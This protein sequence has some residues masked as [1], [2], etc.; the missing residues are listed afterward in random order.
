[1]VSSDI[2]EASFEK[3][4]TSKSRGISI[5]QFESALNNIGI[6]LTSREIQTIFTDVNRNL[7]SDD[8]ARI[9]L[10]EILLSFKRKG[11]TGKS[12]RKSGG[13]GDHSDVLI[14]DSV[15]EDLSQST[16]AF[17]KV[18]K[19]SL[20]LTF[21]VSTTRN[22][23]SS[24]MKKPQYL[25][26]LEK[27]GCQLEETHLNL[28]YEIFDITLE[29]V[30]S[31]EN[32]LL[33]VY[34]ISSSTMDMSLEPAVILSQICHKR[35]IGSKDFI[36]N[37]L[38]YE[39]S[40][41]GYV[42]APSFESV[43][44]KL[45]GTRPGVTTSQL[46]D[47]LR[48]FDPDEDN[49]IDIGLLLSFLNTITSPQRV[50]E[51]FKH[52]L[53][54][55]RIKELSY[56]AV[57]Q[58][59]PEKISCDD[60]IEIVNKLNLP[61]VEGE[62]YVLFHKLCD[63]HQQVTMKS[64]LELMER[65]SMNATAAGAGGT[66]SR[67]SRLL[68]SKGAAATGE[69]KENEFCRT[70]YQKLCQLRSNESKRDR[71]REGIL[72]RDPDLNG[73]ITIRE[74]E[75]TIE[76]FI[77]FTEVEFNLLAENLCFID[78]NFTK[79]I[80]YSFLLL[81]MFEPIHK[82]AAVMEH[83]KAIMSKML[84]TDDS[85]NLRR[86]IALLFRNFASYDDHKS[87]MITIGSAESVLKEEIRQAS[88][89]KGIVKLLTAFQDPNSDCVLY[90]ELLSFLG[91]CSLWNVMYRLHLVDKLRKKQGFHF[92][93]HL[94]KMTQKHKYKLTK[95]K[96]FEVFLG[97]GILITDT[98][99]ETIFQKYRHPQKEDEREEDR[100]P[101]ALDAKAFVRDLNE[102][103]SSGDAAPMKKDRKD[104]TT[105][106][107]KALTSDGKCQIKETLLKKYDTR[108][109]RAIDLAFDLFD[110]NS[111]NEIA[112][113][114]IERV[115]C[116]LGQKPS[117]AD[118]EMLLEKI[119]PNGKDVLEYNTFMDVVLPYIRGKYDETF[120]PSLQR[121]Q[122][123]FRAFDYNKDGTV[124]YGEFK[125]ILSLQSEEVD[126]NEAEE[127]LKIL[128]TNDN[129]IVE[130]AEFAEMYQILRDEPA[131]LE[132]DLP[133]RSAL[134]KVQRSLLHSLASFPLSLLWLPLS[135]LICSLSQ[136]QYSALPDPEK[137]LSIFAGLPSNYRLSVLADLENHSKHKLG[138]IVCPSK[139]LHSVS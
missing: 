30:I 5:E 18:S 134:R 123:A 135:S 6:V 31:C 69:L 86:L 15:I 12:G 107:Q 132:L 101:D 74:L 71:F 102:M 89:H 35:R 84:T 8:N 124:S 36:K 34:T 95:E 78:G 137:Y 63:K 45:A 139:Y 62:V 60:L 83:G 90:P 21:K 59:Y 112:A 125:Y 53:K 14:P 100:H 23:S 17:L 46:A 28:L 48:Y 99:L 41:T 73:R 29:D 129:G 85:V 75:R 57:F 27:L 108:M 110:Q 39:T 117:P 66:S 126:D 2:L 56:Q 98:A 72:S 94:L 119:D 16:Q 7:G 105:W 114:D 127:L 116:A 4:V 47:L 122:E 54:L 51:K 87:G 133:T 97:I 9:P 103:E 67:M 40:K 26:L 120:L 111:R 113:L 38:P 93:D 37:L 50:E 10:N 109:L 118:I 64:F 52:Y 91:S 11:T 115:L 136:L 43:L 79:D 44:K 80:D 121:L 32:L 81:V 49:R 13:R 77:D 24:V 76:K 55:M 33:Y 130:W 128:D 20:S 42:T 131:M 58:S 88:D 82:S 61:L 104:I 68:G 1:M 70:M 96:L 106:E 65:D 25:Q 138:S 92:A 22:N 19:H 3:A